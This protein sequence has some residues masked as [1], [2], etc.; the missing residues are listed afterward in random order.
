MAGPTPRVEIIDSHLRF[1]APCDG[2][3][4]LSMTLRWSQIGTVDVTVPG[5]HPRAG[6]LTTPGAR[7]RVIAG[8]R[9][10][11]SGPIRTMAGSGPSDASTLT[12]HAEDDVRLLWRL[13]IWP[14]PS[15]APSGA[16][17]SKMPAE[18]RRITGPAETVVKTLLRENIRRAER[19]IVIAPDQGRGAT[20]SASMRFNTIGE[21]LMGSIDNKGLG[22]TV[23]QE[24]DHLLVDTPQR[25]VTERII[26][27]ESG[28]IS[29][30]SWTR[31]A[32][33]ATTIVIGGQG[34]GKD[35]LFTQVTN[36]EDVEAWGDVVEEFQDARNNDQSTSSLRDDATE[37]L[38]GKGSLT[39]L[40]VTLSPSAS[41]EF[42]R[43][44][45]IW[46]GDMVFA[47][48]A[49][50]DTWEI[51]REVTVECSDAGDGWASV[52][53]TFGDY[54]DNPSELLSRRIRQIA[55]GV[56]D[57]QRV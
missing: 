44:E 9:Q 14:S 52:K 27:E 47:R 42:G 1:V 24:D 5:D 56:R 46:P 48:I 45:S 21:K 25:R 40:S 26:S 15:P 11:F 29:Q 57:L 3:M 35:R 49:G 30:W 18:Y 22:V 28:M 36:Q 38:S 13:L 19:P 20:M 12:V 37:T 41:M 43:P 50:V 23:T 39:G 10:V 33:T 7:L 32:P 34:E 4:S 6:L 31:A 16:N 17:G 51:V 8:G 55:R 2:Y 53:P 54:A